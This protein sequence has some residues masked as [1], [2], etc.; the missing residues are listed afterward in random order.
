[1]EGIGRM[2]ASRVISF[3]HSCYGCVH[4]GAEADSNL[5]LLGVDLVGYYSCIWDKQV[6]SSF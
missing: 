3:L 1:M 4:K 2:D 5:G 6:C